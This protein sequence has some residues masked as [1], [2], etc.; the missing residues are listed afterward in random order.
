[1]LKEKEYW[2]TKEIDKGKVWYRI[3][4]RPGSKDTEG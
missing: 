2:R 1:M 4:L 3:L